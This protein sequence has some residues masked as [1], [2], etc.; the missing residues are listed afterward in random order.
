MER[1]STQSY[2]EV[3]S[4]LIE[5]CENI[6]ECRI[7]NESVLEKT[8]LLSE[9]PK[10]KYFCH[11]EHC[12]CVFDNIDEY[13]VHVLN[14]KHVYKNLRVRAYEIMEKISYSTDTAYCPQ[15]Q[16]DYS[17]QKNEEIDFPKFQEFFNRGFAFE[18]LQRNNNKFNDRTK[19]WLD[20]EFDAWQKFDPQTQKW[21]TINVVGGNFQGLMDR[22]I[23]TFPNVEDQLTE[24]QIRSYFSRLRAKIKS[25][26]N[27]ARS[28]DIINEKVRN[29]VIQELQKIQKNN[30]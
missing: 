29:E 24:K 25:G 11:L 12:T 7:K 18:Q 8:K 17:P 1:L 26:I 28:Q 10:M 21:K 22:F 16:K 19:A 30:D 6:L 2:I 23:E 14:G 13:H 27:E 9:F 15:I 5:Q 20:K 4:S 3:T